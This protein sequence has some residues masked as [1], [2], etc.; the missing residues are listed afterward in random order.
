[1]G[2]NAL[3]RHQ[4]PNSIIYDIA[5]GVSPLPMA[6]SIPL[7]EKANYCDYKSGSS[8]IHIEF[9]F[10]NVSTRFIDSFKELK[11]GLQD[12]NQI[13][14]EAFQK[15][16]LEFTHTFTDLQNFTQA[17]FK[18]I[19]Q[20][21]DLGASYKD[22]SNIIDQF[23]H[24]VKS[25]DHMNDILFE[26]IERYQTAFKDLDLS[27]PE[28]NKLLQRT[29]RFLANPE[30]IKTKNT[31]E[32][33]FKSLYSKDLKLKN[34]ESLNL[35][36][37]VIEEYKNQVLVNLA[38]NFSSKISSDN[39]R[40]TETLNN[41]RFKNIFHTILDLYQLSTNIALNPTNPFLRRNYSDKL[42]QKEVLS[43]NMNELTDEQRHAIKTYLESIQNPSDKKLAEMKV[44]DLR[45]AVGY[46]KGLVEEV[47]PKLLQQDFRTTVNIIKNYIEGTMANEVSLSQKYYSPDSPKSHNDIKSL[48]IRPLDLAQTVYYSSLLPFNMGSINESRATM[49]TILLK[50]LIDDNLID[51]YLEEKKDQHQNIG[52]EFSDK[53]NFKIE[54]IIDCIPRGAFD[55]SG[56]DLILIIKVPKDS[57][58][59]IKDSQETKCDD[60][61]YKYQIIPIQIKSGERSAI[62]S[63][64][65]KY[66]DTPAVAAN[67]YKPSF[68]RIPLEQR[69][70]SLFSSG[71]TETYPS[72][73]ATELDRRIDPDLPLK[74]IRAINRASTQDFRTISSEQMQHFNTLL[75][76]PKLFTVKG[77]L[78]KT[79]NSESEIELMNCFR[80]QG[81]LKDL[82]LAYQKYPNDLLSALNNGYPKLDKQSINKFAEDV[83]VLSGY[84]SERL[85]RDPNFRFDE[86]TIKLLHSEMHDHRIESAYL[87]PIVFKMLKEYETGH[88]FSF[89]DIQ[90]ITHPYKNEAHRMKK[91]LNESFKLEKTYLEKYL[92]D[93]LSINPFLNTH[94]IKNLI[95]VLIK[96]KN[97]F[98]VD[99]YHRIQNSKNARD[100]IKILTEISPK[101]KT[102]LEFSPI[103]LTQPELTPASA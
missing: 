88:Q 35:A 23:R 6:A 7:P 95:P 21:N 66:P 11:K 98:G 64:T 44:G 85:R 42:I 17:R 3:I 82:S 29:S 99:F 89:S 30:N 68:K 16:L 83:N 84:L 20:E 34:N 38:K 51:K 61:N 100:I 46:R 13:S 49:A 19:K 4:V 94:D 14:A 80:E 18:Q 65:Y 52:L 53:V 39:S 28:L 92:K 26:T 91:D 56:S 57:H 43:Q 24:Q 79:V 54:K 22:C 77:D 2:I 12:H 93:M 58:Q 102:P 15:Q 45:H 47:M 69:K 96:D 86:V 31:V 41:K 62:E 72:D 90:S 37:D 73:A 33:I 25:L 75:K 71:M 59:E 74:L 87:K 103:N 101:S 60:Q 70:H 48:A 40:M 63:E 9:D 27:K 36:H 97:S 5:S 32:K 76:N 1:M 50:Q 81:F 67:Q 55:I 10:T 78:I 8:T